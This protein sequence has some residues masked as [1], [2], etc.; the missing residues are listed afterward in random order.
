M[1]NIKIDM[2]AS[3]I[4]YL[5]STYQAE[6]LNHCM[7][8]YFD[9]IVEDPEIKKVNKFA[10]D[11]CEN[12]LISL[13]SL[14]SK[15]NIPIPVGINDS[16]ILTTT[17][18]LYTDPFILY[19]QWFVGKGNLNYASLAINTIARD[20]IF[21][22][23]KNL[24][25]KS[26]IL[27]EDSRRMLLSKGLWIRAPYIP[28]PTEVEFIKKESFL[29]GWFNDKRP[30]AGIEIASIF[31]NLMTNAIGQSLISSFVQITDKGELR[32]YFIRGKDIA[33]K[34]I[35][36]MSKH[37]KE[38]EIPVP[39]TWNTGVTSSKEPPF[40]EKLMLTLVT[41]LNAQG[42]SNYGNAISNSIKRDIGLDFTRLAAEVA[43]YGE[44]GTKLLIKHGWMEK[45]PLAKEI[46]G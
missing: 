18:R 2:T 35:D 7:L 37:L 1:E 12:N 39:N 6:T 43:K 32:D 9:K 34:H 36:L 38:Q 29:N 25:T 31:Y 23:Y 15:D 21:D 16:D 45:P 30:L 11:S 22:F 17:D 19:F 26:L 14:F 41:F 4:G 3:E 44:D 24:L 8:T 46:I 42:L 5:W 28:V 27:L 20:D 40:S 33:E 13:K 10:L